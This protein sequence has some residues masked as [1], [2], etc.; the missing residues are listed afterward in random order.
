M[1]GT[2]V[3]KLSVSDSLRLPAALVYSTDTLPVK[4]TPLACADSR[5]LSKS[6]AAPRI[7]RW[8]AA[9]P[10]P[11]DSMGEGLSCVAW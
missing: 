2:H 7:A 4:V 3:V 10:S 1:R 8:P 9:L 11:G 6:R 5:K